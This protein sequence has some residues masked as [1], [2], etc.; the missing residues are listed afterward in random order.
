MS[1]TE[2]RD[3]EL[4]AACAALTVFSEFGIPP[5]V[6]E[7]LVMGN[8]KMGIKP[9]ALSKAVKAILKGFAARSVT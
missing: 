6:Q 7:L 8:P 5:D 4:D 9:G 1:I 3:P 2:V